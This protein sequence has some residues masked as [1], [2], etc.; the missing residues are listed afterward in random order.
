MH[1][2]AMLPPPMTPQPCKQ[3]SNI[4]P[5][6]G[7]FPPSTPL[8]H[9]PPLRAPPQ[10]TPSLLPRV[11]RVSPQP[12]VTVPPVRS[13]PVIVPPIR[14][15]PALT[16][17]SDANLVHDPSDPESD[18]SN[19]NAGQSDEPDIDELSEDEDDRAAHRLLRATP[20]TAGAPVHSSPANLPYNH[21][22][23][24]VS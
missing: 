4:D 15:S 6:L 2:Q 14:S 11:Q 23:F 18:G 12:L 9:V 21:Q 19:P 16:P 20:I 22:G 10:P 1:M 17:P 8:S 3:L 7:F 13:S 5:R 24:S